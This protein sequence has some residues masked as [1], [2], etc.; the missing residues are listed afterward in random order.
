[1]TP[2]TGAP[3]SATLATSD[4]ARGP[5]IE[6]MRAIAVHPGRPGSIHARTVR[7]PAVS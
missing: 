6:T 3:H 1:M 7:R 2:P 5:G 4:T